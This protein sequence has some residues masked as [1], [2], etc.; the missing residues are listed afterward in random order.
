MKDLNMQKV[1]NILDF[2]SIY[3]EGEALWWI[4]NNTFPS[5]A[6]FR[7]V[8]VN[9]ET[10]NKWMEDN[11]SIVRTRSKMKA[12]SQK[13][14]IEQVVTHLKYDENVIIT[15]NQHELPKNQYS[16][17]GINVFYSRSI[18]PNFS[19]ELFEEEINL[20]KLDEEKKSQVYMVVQRHGGLDLQ[21]FEIDIPTMDIE[22]NYG[23][24]WASKHEDLMEVL[25]F[26]KK[27]GIALLH[28]LPGTGKSMYIRHLISTLSER[29]TVIYLPNQLIS[30]I[31][32]P[33]FIPLMAE[34]SGSIL[35]IED[36]DEAIK[37]R[38]NGG[39]TVDK[40]LNLADGIL[41]DFLGMQIICTFNNDLSTIDEA[42]L[43]KGRLI[44][45]HEFDKLSIESAQKLSDKLGF[46][47]VI[48]N[49]MTLAEIYNQEDK[50]SDIKK[51]ETKIGF[52]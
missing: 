21:D 11:L 36:A 22:M 23:S 51:K 18:S 13:L 12:N 5:T 28:G 17:N 37:S 35:V 32:D 3:D 43:R 10:W 39:G 15:W 33:G 1:N 26:K 24:E 49:P 45:K 4:K 47:T 19:L 16:I 27:K 8:Y 30:C 46:K 44:L 2:A 40:L 38:K 52:R 31:T 50:L 7:T 42:L 25:S 34:Y 29:K 14:A 48:E 41:S 9:R 20:I 6:K